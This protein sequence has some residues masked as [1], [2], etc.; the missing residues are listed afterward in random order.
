MD[1]FIGEIRIFTWDWAPRGW[2][3]CNGALMNLQQNAALYALIGVL[4]GGNG[5]TNFNLPDLRGRSPRHL[6]Q[7]Q[8]QVGLSGGAENVVLTAAN[9]PAHTHSTNVANTTGTTPPAALVGR[10]PGNGSTANPIYIPPAQAGA[11]VAL[12]QASIAIAGSS[13]PVPNMQPWIT[14][15]YCIAISGLFPPRN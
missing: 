4:Y 9:L 8:P 2:A 14:A 13:A 12:N 7:Q 5:T 10:L 3:L 6:S 1:P 15:N 11:P